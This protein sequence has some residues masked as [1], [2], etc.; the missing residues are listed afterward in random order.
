MKA[1]TD[2][3]LCYSCIPARI[4]FIFLTFL[5]ICLVYAFKS[6]LGVAIVAMVGHN[7]T[8]EN[9]SHECHT[10]DGSH[11]NSYSVG[12]FDWDDHQQAIILGAFFYGYIITQLPAGVL[13][14][15]FGAKWIFGGSILITAILSLLGPEA[16][17]WGFVPFFLT[18][19]GQGLAEGV[20]IP[21]M[22]AM[23]ARWIPKMERSRA[24]SII[25][26]GSA[27][28]TV[29]TLPLTGY[30][31]DGT[32]MGGWPAIFYVLGIAGC[33]WFVFWAIFIYD[34]PERHPFISQ[35]E[36]K[37]INEGQGREKTSEVSNCFV[38]LHK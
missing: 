21:C 23:I 11:E 5:G 32:F 28:G 16:A 20:T 2:G 34:T 14:E 29:V 30:L 7:S 17:R 22:N 15:K 19:F 26:S 38:N 13:S 36:I 35:K 9:S 8:T 3:R 6:L 1:Q 24:T 31:C 27:I 18:R 4:I 10:E 33:V 12:E 25:L 37:F